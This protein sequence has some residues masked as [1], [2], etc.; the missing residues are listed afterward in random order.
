MKNNFTFEIFTFVFIWAL[1]TN[2]ASGQYS[3]G[4]TAGVFKPTLNGQGSGN[5]Y[6][7]SLGLRYHHG[8]NIRLGLNIG[9]YSKESNQS[10]IGTKV[11]KMSFTPITLEGL[12]VFSDNKIKPGVGLNLGMYK[13]SLFVFTTS[14]FGLAPFVSCAYL[15]NEQF[16]FSAY[17]K[18]HYFLTLTDPAKAPEFSVGINYIFNKP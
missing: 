9:R 4:V 18:Y 15:L 6:G 10:F 17:L 5:Y 2:I 7:G 11:G 16:E 3:V 14:K 8:E 1:F 12:Y 13:Q